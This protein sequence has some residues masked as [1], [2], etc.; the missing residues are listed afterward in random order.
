MNLEPDKRFGA[1]PSGTDYDYEALKSH[2]FFKG[3][4]FKKLSSIPPPVPVE[5][6][7]NAFKSS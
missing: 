2:P 1:G 3:I 5:K 6:F 4:N 7:Q